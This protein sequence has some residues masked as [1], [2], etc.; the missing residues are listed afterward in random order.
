VRGPIWS[1]PS[2]GGTRNYCGTSSR[3]VNGPDLCESM[4]PGALVRWPR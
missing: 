3:A 1:S 4:A 2:T